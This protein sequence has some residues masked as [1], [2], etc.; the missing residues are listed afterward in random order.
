M[1]GTKI[2]K[3]MEGGYMPNYCIDFHKC[4]KYSA[5]IYSASY[6]SPFESIADITK[7]IR[8][9]LS[10]AGFILFDL[11]LSNGDGF[12]RFA[13]AY[14]DGYEIKR[15]TICVINLNDANQLKYFNSHYKGRTVELN[16]SVL[17]PSEKYMHSR[18]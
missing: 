11:L 5:V 8:I 9:N 10:D 15:E 7:E 4:D 13:E 3:R 12:N 14:F 18:I 16:N 17:A 2:D 6:K 1:S